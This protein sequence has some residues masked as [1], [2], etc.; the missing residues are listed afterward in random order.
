MWQFHRKTANI[1]QG[2]GDLSTYSP[3]SEIAKLYFGFERVSGF[4]NYSVWTSYKFRK[5]KTICDS[6]NKATK[7]NWGNPIQK[8]EKQQKNGKSLA[9]Q[10]LPCGNGS[11]N[12]EKDTNLQRK[13]QNYIWNRKMRKEARSGEKISRPQPLNN[14][15]ASFRHQRGRNS[16]DPRPANACTNSCG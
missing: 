9:Q 5:D 6:T 10:G 15:L 7:L 8:K 3:Y 16:T 2:Q 14:S 1:D 12:F 11:Y 13:N 4:S